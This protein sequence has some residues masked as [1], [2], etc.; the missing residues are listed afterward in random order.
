MTVLF[1][2]NGS[3][4]NNV[5]TTNVITNSNDETV[6]IPAGYYTLSEIIALLNTMSDTLFSISTNASS[7]GCIWIQ[8]PHTIDFTDAPD[9]REILGFDGRTVILPASFY[10]SN[11]IDI[12]RNRQVIQVYSTIVRSSDLKI[13]NQN[14]NLLTTMI[15]DDPTADYVRSVEDV[16]IPMIT[17]F[18]QLMFVFRDME[19]KM[20]RLNGEFELQLTIEDVMEEVPSSI[21]SANQFS[22]IEVFGNTT[23]KEVKLNN[24]L[25]FDQCYI[26]SVSLYTDFVL[27]NVPTDQVVLIN[28]GATIQE[29]AIPRG[30][31]DIETI[32]AKLN[33]SDA[34]FELVYSG[35]NAFHITVDHFYMIDFTNAPEIRSILGFE[36]D[37][38]VKGVDN[39]KRYYLSSSCNHVV[40]TDSRESHMLT[41][42]VG[43]YTFSEFIEAVGAEMVKVLPLTS[44]TIEDDHVRFNVQADGWYFDRSSVDT[45]ID[46]FGWTPWFKLASTVRN[47]CIERPVETSFNPESDSPPDM[48]NDQG[49]GGHAYIG[50]NTFIAYDWKM[51][52]TDNRFLLKPLATYTMRLADGSVLDSGEFYITDD[53]STPIKMNTLTTTC[54]NEL[55][56]RYASAMELPPSHQNAIAWTVNDNRESMSW[57]AKDYAP[58]LELHITSENTGDLVSSNGSSIGPWYSKDSIYHTRVFIDTTNFILGIRGYGERPLTIQRGH[59]SAIDI[60]NMIAN[61]INK[62]YVD[63]SLGGYLVYVIADNGGRVRMGCRNGTEPRFILFCDNPCFKIIPGPYAEPGGVYLSCYFEFYRNYY[64]R[65]PELTSPYEFAMANI[66]G[67]NVT[68]M[69]KGSTYSDRAV[70][71]EFIQ[72]TRVTYVRNDEVVVPSLATFVDWEQSESYTANTTIRFPYGMMTLDEEGSSASPET[73]I[74]YTD[75]TVNHKWTIPSRLTQADMIWHMNQCFD[76]AALDIRWKAESDG[77]YI[78]ADHVFSLSGN[79]GTIIPASGSQSH[80]WRIPFDDGVYYANYGPM[81]AEYPVDITN[82]LSNIQ[83][84]CNIVKSKTIPL[85]A[86]VPMDSLY[87]NYFYKNRMLVPCSELLDRIV[88]ELKDENGDPLSFIGNVYLLIGFTVSG[89]NNK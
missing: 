48:T 4:F 40:V 13:A 71:I 10:G 5:D 50:S 39:P 58:E 52:T 61:V 2:P 59:Y 12:T 15:I 70:S 36:S 30:A 45:T 35:E 34:L 86:N 41:L 27:H 51:R 24:P 84:Y 87:K 57:T 31:Y 26:S 89:G 68:N 74:T 38:L 3:M 75:D 78:H 63:A 67:L 32:I 56:A 7:F 66:D 82:G 14:N 69:I 77:Y 23:K 28:A 22:M 83:L 85:L 1:H 60:V 73:D 33:A 18:D 25:S 46:G 9:I 11:V 88:Y 17:R 8:S 20:I 72:P 49:I 53:T 81:V 19:G 42:P 6:T 47:L 29:I 80:T 21:A 62:I 65:M 54:F 43:Y 64:I 55:N 37:I 79:L 44:M 16:R 76:S